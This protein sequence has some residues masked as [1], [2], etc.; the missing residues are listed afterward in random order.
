MRI[1]ITGA[2]GFVGPH[3]VSK[4]RSEEPSAEIWRLVWDADPGDDPRAARVDLREP[5]PLAAL[6]D[7]VRPDVVYHLAAASSVATSWTEPDACFSVNARGTANL[8]VAAGELD[9]LPLVVAVTSGEAY[10]DTGPG[11]RAREDAPLRPRSPYALSKAAQDGLLASSAVPAVRLRPFLH[12]GPGQGDRFALPSFARRIAEAELGLRPPRLEVGNLDAV[13]DVT[14]VRDVTRAYRMA[15][16][17]RLAGGVF[18]VASGAGHRVGDLL[19]ILLG[20]AR[21]PIEVVQNAE[22]LRP[23]DVP[24]LVGDPGRFE[25]ATGWRPKI[26]LEQTLSDLLSWWRERLGGGALSG[27]DAGTGAGAGGDR[28]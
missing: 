8:L 17:R 27:T 7:R 18:N 10:G 21:R 25:E 19:G 4:L 9:P 28:S 5:G 2:D 6:L 22:R 3:L 26:P 16:D 20:V 12:T 23:A 1:L 13:R 15:A 14:D 11:G 24:H